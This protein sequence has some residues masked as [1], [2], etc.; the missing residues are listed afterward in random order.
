M[1]KPRHLG[2]AWVSARR[3]RSGNLGASLGVVLCAALLSGAAAFLLL[4]PRGLADAGLLLV[5][6]LALLALTLLPLLVLLA[7]LRGAL[8]P[9]LTR[10]LA[11]GGAS[12]LRLVLLSHG[13]CS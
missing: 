5:P 4:L 2:D 11:G 6:L 10:L 9:L 13:S 1:K 12:L 8:L 7:G 3:R